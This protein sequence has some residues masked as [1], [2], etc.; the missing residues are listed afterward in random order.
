MP[1]SGR[2]N[3]FPNASETRTGRA[4][5]STK[6]ANLGKNA[7]IKASRQGIAHTS[8]S[9]SRVERCFLPARLGD[10]ERNVG[11]E[12]AKDMSR[13]PKTYGWGGHFAR[14][15]ESALRHTL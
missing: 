13:F 4:N 1:N 2:R 3:M 9:R 12:W 8:R 7:A 11:G 15:R 14:H 10:L 5:H 6:N